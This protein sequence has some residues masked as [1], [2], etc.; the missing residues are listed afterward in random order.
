VGEEGL[1]YLETSFLPLLNLGRADRRGCGKVDPLVSWANL[2]PSHDP[3]NA[4][5]RIRLQFQEQIQRR[6]VLP[7]F[8]FRQLRLS[9]TENLAEVCLCQVKTANFADAA[10]DFL[11]VRSKL[12]ILLDYITYSSV[13]FFMRITRARFQLSYRMWAVAKAIV[14]NGTDA[15]LY[16]LDGNGGANDALWMP[17]PGS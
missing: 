12:N 15:G 11:E 13:L 6:C 5:A 14:T 17:R 4:P 3:I 10:T 8:V 7:F 9:N 16:A 1:R 2:F